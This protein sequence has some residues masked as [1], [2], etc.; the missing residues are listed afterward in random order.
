MKP[1]FYLIAACA[2]S[3]GLIQDDVVEHN[4]FFIDPELPDGNYHVT[5]GRD[6]AAPLV[7]RWHAK[8]KRWHRLEVREPKA[9][10]WGSGEYTFV[11]DENQG[12]VVDVNLDLYA[13]SK[14][15]VPVSDTGCYHSHE[16]ETFNY[17]LDADDY[18]HTKQSF[19]NWCDL[20][21]VNT[22]HVELA[23]KGN[24]AVYVC[25]RRRGDTKYC[26]EAEFEDCEA[27][28]NR[29]CGAGPAW[30]WI[31][32]WSKEYGRSWKGQK[33]CGKTGKYFTHPSP[34][35][36]DDVKISSDTSR[37][38]PEHERPEWKYHGPGVATGGKKPRGA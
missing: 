6:G 4:G 9:K 27:H 12:R 23:L 7:K 15:P 24:V 30:T 2:T 33:V 10:G 5:M 29:T 34:G 28:M 22:G 11:V 17:A 18:R 19:Y 1:I 37:G 36:W 14:L 3:A 32:D 13:Q 26:S 31:K 35:Y 8:E 21:P 25:M 20:Y 16:Y 38:R